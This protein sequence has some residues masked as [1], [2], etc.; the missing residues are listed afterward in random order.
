MGTPTLEG[1]CEIRVGYSMKD[2]QRGFQCTADAQCTCNSL[3]DEGWERIKIWSGNHMA[4]RVAQS[5][6]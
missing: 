5:Q 2:A 4:L 1:R 6:V 3:S